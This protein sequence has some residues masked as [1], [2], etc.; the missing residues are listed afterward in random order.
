MQKKCSVKL[1]IIAVSLPQN[2]SLKSFPHPSAK[3]WELEEGG[4]KK[5]APLIL[6]RE[7]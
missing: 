2:I 5:K 7:T 4:G 3:E 6:S 1:E